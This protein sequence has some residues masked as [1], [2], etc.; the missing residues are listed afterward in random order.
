V[1]DGV[2]V[3]GETQGIHFF[4]RQLVEVVLLAFRKTSKQRTI[5]LKQF[6]ESDIIGNIREAL[7][8]IIPCN[9]NTC[10]RESY[11]NVM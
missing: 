2:I 10:A 8:C 4:I 1:H 6:F 11:N 9:N 5:T 7:Y 3:I